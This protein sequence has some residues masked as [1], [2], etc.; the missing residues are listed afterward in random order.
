[1]F[2]AANGACVAP[3][4]SPLPP[5]PRRAPRAAATGK[6]VAEGAPA[7]PLRKAAVKPIKGRSSHADAVT[8]CRS[9]KR[10]RAASPAP[11]APAPEPA[12]AAAAPPAPPPAPPL[13]APELRSPAPRPLAKPP[14]PPPPAS[15]QQ[16]SGRSRG[17]G[18]STLWTT[19]E[20]NALVGCA[21]PSFVRSLAFH[22]SGLNPGSR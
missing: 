13:R 22:H 2:A 5:A 14:P 20:D 17:S 12:P 6:A 16:N 8:P 15:S 3:S 7:A 10:K 21:L 11:P 9:G 4:A 18:S 19:D 1:M